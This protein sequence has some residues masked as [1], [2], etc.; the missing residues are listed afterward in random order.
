[1]DH[2]NVTT[3]KRPKEIPTR[4][5]LAAIF[6]PPTKKRRIAS[7]P[8]QTKT[9]TDPSSAL[10]NSVPPNIIPIIHPPSI[11]S[12]FFT[13][14]TTDL[15]NKRI[16]NQVQGII[17]KFPPPIPPI[18]PNQSDDE[19]LSEDE[20]GG[21]M[22]PFIYPPPPVIDIDKLPFS[23]A[24]FKKKFE[25]KRRDLKA[26]DNKT[27]EEDEDD[28]EKEDEK[29][30]NEDDS[31][32]LEANEIST[33]QH[34]DGQ[35][36]S[37]KFYVQAPPL[38]FPPKNYMSYPLLAEKSALVPEEVFASFLEANEE[39]PRVDMVL[40][41]A[42]GSLFDLR[43][44]AIDEGLTIEDFE[45]MTKK[46]HQI[47]EDISADESDNSTKQHK[48]DERMKYYQKID[49]KIYEDPYKSQ[50]TEVK[51]N[52]LHRDPKYDLINSKISNIKG[53]T[54]R[55][56][57]EN[58][59][60]YPRNVDYTFARINKISTA[61]KDVAS[62]NG[63]LKERR[64]KALREQVENLEEYEYQNRNKIYNAQ[65]FEL[66]RRLNNLKSSKIKFLNSTIKDEELDNRNKD[67]EIERDYEL[68]KLKI[69]EKYELLKNSLLFYEDS[70]KIY[71][72]LN[73]LLIKKLEKL[74]NFF[75]YQRDVFEKLIEEPEKDEEEDELAIFDIASKESSKLFNGISSDAAGEPEE[76]EPGVSST[77]SVI[78][79]LLNSSSSNHP[80]V[81]D[82]MPL[83]SKEE[84]DIITSDVPKNLK[85]S[86]NIKTSRKHQIFAGSIYDKMM[87]SGSDT[88]TSDTN[89]NN[90]QPEKPA[91]KRRGRRTIAPQQPNNGTISGSDRNGTSLVL[92]GGT[93]TT[94]IPSIDR[95]NNLDTKYSE[96][97]LL[98]KI[99]K[100]FYGPQMARSDEM[101]KDLELMGIKTKWPIK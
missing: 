80:L 4:E 58:P 59:Y 65:K 54:K 63:N 55:P 2:S 64:R 28:D 52:Q 34:T 40:A 82:F 57:Y 83:I 23:L 70:N 15:S 93:S 29:D 61:T 79:K 91:P 60:S 10:L 97:A 31:Y 46:L 22:I 99:N 12:D 87:T 39:I 72:S 41:S 78:N 81:H 101:A 96:A 94:T 36:S 51:Q 85:P 16:L 33:L 26:K 35:K 53:I 11:T 27:D 6:H 43:K 17:K 98:A 77:D 74:K 47:E 90:G 95:S 3:F 75:E 1:M 50:W 42:A 14:V 38:P 100:Q 8:S 92:G 56:T 45:I 66:L 44:E 88:N 67:L 86:T 48:L 37:H 30:D 71:K 84:F 25:E 21:I 7:T 62:A 18:P 32:D 24:S 19:Y 73:S 13:D 9:S 68:V 69:F 20:K 49:T 5:Q 76:D 89:K